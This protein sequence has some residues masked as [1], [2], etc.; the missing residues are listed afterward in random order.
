MNRPYSP[1][2]FVI[3]LIYSVQVEV[4][5]IIHE[6]LQQITGTRIIRINAD[7]VGLLPIGILLQGCIEN[8]EDGYVILKEAELLSCVVDEI[9]SWWRHGGLCD[10]V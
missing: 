6:F 3:I 9:V 2:L 8:H 5:G 7:I 1:L 4:T 10:C